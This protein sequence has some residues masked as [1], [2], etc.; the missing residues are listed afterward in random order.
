MRLFY[1]LALGLLSSLATAQSFD[2]YGPTPFGDLL[3]HTVDV[4]WAP[5]AV[6]SL[7]NRQYVMLFTPGQT[8]VLVI[9]PADITDVKVSSAA[10][11]SDGT[12]TYETF[13]SAVF[14]MVDIN[15][16]EV[17]DDREPDYVALAGQYQIS[18][19]LHSY[20]GLNTLADGSLA[21]TD[22]GTFY[23]NEATETGYVAVEFS[24][25][26]EAATIQ[27]VRQWEYDAGSGS[28]VEVGD[29]TP[30]W[31]QVSGSTASWTTTEANAT[32]FFVADATS[33]LSM[34][35]ADGSDFNP[36]QIEYQPNAT[37]EL[38]EVEAM[39]ASKLI[40]ELEMRVTAE[41]QA[42]MG[43]ST[44]A[45]E[46]ASAQLDSIEA[47]LIA[48]GATLR[49][50]KEFYLALRENMLSH[51]VASTDIYNAR[52]GYQTVPHVYFTNAV[53]D[54]GVPHPFM[55]MATH[56]VST[57]PNQLLDVNRP[58]GA[59]Q[60]V[61][62]A[63]STV[64]RH[65]KLGEFLVKV[66]LKDYGL[67]DDLLDNVLDTDLAA[68]FDDKMGTTTTKTVYNYTSLA[69]CGMAV[70]GVTIYPA[71]NNNLRFA[72]E[73]AEVTHSG[74]HVGG[75]LE[76]HYH[77]D[78][79]AFNGNGINLYNLSDYEGHDHPPVIGMAF[80]GIALFG[81]YEDSYS[82]MVGYG[83]ALDDF[84]G[85]D[86]GDDFGYHYHAHA[87]NHESDNAPGTFFDEHF[88]LVGAWKGLVNDIPGWE[89]GKM[90]QFNDEAIARYVGAEYDEPVDPEEPPVTG[91][92][93]GF[94]LTIYPNPSVGELKL[95]TEGAFA[96]QLVNLAGKQVWQ[97]A[98]QPGLNTLS[99]GH[100]P[101][102]TYLLKGTGEV[103]HF[104]YPVVLKD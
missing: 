51:T 96:L 7:A 41:Y 73:D 3:N 55:V 87:E 74:I 68:D 75:G 10:G 70:D 13:L 42:Q 5:P 23:I 26:P 88:L 99:L 82:S 100:L 6:S 81:R 54:D 17:N 36:A 71:Q 65:G 11:L 63:Q 2:Y 61:G 52:I 86:H 31:L 47:D 76:L 30:V 101:A 103:G 25:T 89:E 34:Q 39:E 91:L 78:G 29:F 80:D 85:H 77:A 16:H 64:T 19:F 67:V 24:G 44:S 53:D 22:G 48:A 84:G 38:P 92:P 40:T 72:V 14:Q 27:A 66:P 79:H 9:N 46:A 21:S 20:Y 32:A 15:T 50:P 60:G 93:E 104:V 49:Y 33:Q 18:P 4:S 43:S 94:A 83:V 57:R 90:N 98:V 28:L 69:S 56:A 59:E 1:S 97:G 45:T 58:P 102:G 35:I 62:Y 37:A 12:T 95:R 8:D